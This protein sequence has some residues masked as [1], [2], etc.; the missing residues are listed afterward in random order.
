MRLAFV[1]VFALGCAAS[2]PAPVSEVHLAAAPE[3]PIAT[4][5][6]P[7]ASAPLPPPQQ[8][9]AGSAQTA[10]ALQIDVQEGIQGHL[11]ILVEGVTVFSED[12]SPVSLVGHVASV[13]AHPKQWPVDVT[14]RG[15]RGTTRSVRVPHATPFLAISGAKLDT[16]LSAKPFEYE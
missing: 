4:Q 6:S 3:A 10:D 7:E 5:S 16:V 8:H 14:V 12:V 15:P 1:L 9:D 11:T 2:A 13:R